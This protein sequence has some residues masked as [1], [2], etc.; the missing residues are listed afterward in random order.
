[1]KSIRSELTYKLLLGSYL[2]LAVAGGWLFLHLK[3][4]FTFQFDRSQLSTATAIANEFEFLGNHFE[5]DPKPELVQRF[6]PGERAEYFQ[7]WLEDGSSLLRSASLRDRDL[8]GTDLAEIEGNPFNLLLPDKRMGRAI[9]VRFV[10]QIYDSDFEGKLHNQKQE[11]AVILVYAASRERLDA[12]LRS[13]LLALGSLGLLLP[14]AITLLVRSVVRRSLSPMDRLAT[15]IRDIQ[16]RQLDRRLTLS[17]LP[18]E[19]TPLVARLNELIQQ[20]Q[21]TMERERRLTDNVSHELRPRWPSSARSPRSSRTRTSGRT[22]SDWQARIA[23][24]TAQMKRSQYPCS[25]ARSETWDCAWKEWWSP[26]L[27]SRAV[28]PELNSWLRNGSTFP[29]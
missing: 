19:V 13:L 4:S 23:I 10:P 18:I 20:L 6:Q 3:N 1:M 2:L 11:V 9:A 21:S 26:C 5:F 14:T 27:P 25:L 28:R 7:F 29:R 12:T 8:P 24:P 16:P 22:S 17:S 15:E